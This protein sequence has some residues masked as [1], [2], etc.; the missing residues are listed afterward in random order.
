MASECPLCQG[1]IAEDFGLIS[2]PACGAS[3]F[4]EM[5]GQVRSYDSGASDGAEPPEQM[6]PIEQSSQGDEDG[7]IE[8]AW[9][10]DGASEQN[11]EYVGSVPELNV[12]DPFS[13]E[14]S[15]ALKLGEFVGDSDGNPHSNPIDET[16]RMVVDNGLPEEQQFSEDLDQVDDSPL[17]DAGFGLDGEVSSEELEE[18]VSDEFPADESGFEDNTLQSAEGEDDLP[19][20]LILGDE[21]EATIQEERPTGDDASTVALN[22]ATEYIPPGLNEPMANLEDMSN[23]ADY[24]NSEDSLGRVG[25]LRVKVSLTGIDSPEIREELREALTDKKFLWDIEEVMRSI[26]GGVLVIDN[27][28]PL[29]A[30]ILLERIKALPLEVSWEQF[31]INQP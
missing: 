13:S 18:G 24:G 3:L 1:P 6:S 22:D 2:C 20:P 29:K 10:D 8:L 12:D 7:A 19:P 21:E 16:E 11:G 26:E 30:A 15:E 17:V 4:I 5:D 23:I 27:A 28:T 31:A 9:D 14:Q 25:P